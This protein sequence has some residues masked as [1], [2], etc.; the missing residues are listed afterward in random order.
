MSRTHSLSFQSYSY[1][2]VEASIC[3]GDIVLYNDTTPS[4]PAQRAWAE[5]LTHT[6]ALLPCT[7]HIITLF[8]TH[9]SDEDD[10]NG[11]AGAAQREWLHWRC[12]ALVVRMIDET[13]TNPMQDPTKFIPYVFFV[14]GDSQ[15][16]GL[17]PLK[18]LLAEVVANASAQ[19]AHFALRQLMTESDQQQANQRLTSQMRNTLRQQILA[20]YQQTLN[21]TLQELGPCTTEEFRR[22]WHAIRE[23]MDDLQPQRAVPAKPGA[24]V[25]HRTALFLASSAYFTLYTLYHI[26]VLRREPVASTAVAAL[27]EGGYAESQ[28]SG[29][30]YLTDEIVFYYRRAPA[31]TVRR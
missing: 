29:D 7:T 21:G 16:Q 5:T 23:A 31:L 28:L 25:R 22:R 15:C 17:W 13:E 6:L 30:Y 10:D 2:E 8:G 26:S 27:Q 11:S 9:A 4:A 12:A 14:H 3:T 19:R 1:E 20:F 24:L 18:T